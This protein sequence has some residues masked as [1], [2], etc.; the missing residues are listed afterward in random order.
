MPVASAL[1]ESE[2]QPLTSLSAPPSHDKA[3]ERD[4]TAAG[5]RPPRSAHGAPAVY[6]ERCPGCRMDQIKNARQGIPYK[7]FFFVWIVTL[8]TSLPIS[9]LFPFLYFMTRDLN[10]AKREE[11]IGFYAGFIGSSYMIGRAITSFYWGVMADRYGRKPVILAGTISVIIFNT[12]FGLSTNYWMAIA[13]RFLLG[14][15][16]GILG[17]VKAYAAEVCR[18]EHQGLGLSLV[19]TALSM[20]L[21]IGPSIGG[22]LAQ[23]TQKY[24]GLFPKNSLFGRFPYF[25]P[26]LCVSM[27]SC[28]VFM[29]CLWLP[30][31][32]HMHQNA[33]GL[34]L[35]AALE[36]GEARFKTEE[37][38]EKSNS[39]LPAPQQN[40]FKNWPLISSI[41][42]Y[43]VI[44]LH[45][46]A[47]T[48][49]FSLWA[50]SD[51]KYG[52]L[53]FTTRDVGEVLAISG[54]S[55]LIFQL[56]VYRRI[57]KFLGPVPSARIAVIFT[58]PLLSI[59]PLFN[60]LSGFTLKLVVNCA[61]VLKNILSVIVITALF[62]LQN[63]SVEQHQRGA[64][65]GIAT[66]AMSVF[67]AIAPASGGALFSLAQKRQSAPFFPGDQMLFVFLNLVLLLGFVLTFRP[68]LSQPKT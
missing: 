23:P 26:C 19:S 63:N 34:K 49:I 18:K 51:R 24:P 57:E 53:S 44:S 16:N 11:D 67:K 1:P 14:S 42:V 58:I 35:Y 61:S 52:G 39:S 56:S 7:E 20:G 38:N 65:N 6:Y 50:V 3:P 64:A 21:I 47:Y 9:S 29:A 22:F 66:T 62:I 60:R 8:C 15:L 32:L 46:M 31:T 10:V 37:N 43:C 25:L 30:E 36:T 12:L 55:L 59:Y 33:K 27:F 13:T 48:E 28:L 54:C 2:Q 68:F 5:P 40:L 4:D 45:N 41:I 17:P